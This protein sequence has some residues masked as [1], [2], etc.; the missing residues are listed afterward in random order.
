[1]PLGLQNSVN[2]KYNKF[3]TVL[4]VYQTHDRKRGCSDL[5]ANSQTHPERAMSEGRFGADFATPAHAEA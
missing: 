4:S 2:R 3:I 1:M 5:G